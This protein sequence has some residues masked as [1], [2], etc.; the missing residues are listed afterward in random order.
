VSKYYFDAITVEPLI[1]QWQKLDPKSPE[2][3]VIF[4]EI[5]KP[6]LAIIN[7]IIF[8]HKFTI[9][10]PFDDLQQTA[11]EAVMTA[12]QRYNPN[13]SEFVGKQKDLLFNY[14]SL[15]AYRCLKFYTTRNKK[16]RI[17]D[18]ID[19]LEEREYNQ[20]NTTSLTIDMFEKYVRS[21]E[22][23]LLKFNRKVYSKHYLCKGGLLDIYFSCLR[24]YGFYNNKIYYAE[25]S[26]YFKEH[27]VNLST[28]SER[29]RVRKFISKLKPILA[30]CYSLYK[31]ER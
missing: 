19:G 16:H 24:K 13:Y 21:K 29:A 22:K 14:V 8:T 6:I 7:G 9:W 26:K 27:N 20:D 18:S 11:F 17:T 23:L 28:H 31:N 10:E 2:A 25:V 3:R 1:L 30:K 4:T 12:L 5:T 15:T